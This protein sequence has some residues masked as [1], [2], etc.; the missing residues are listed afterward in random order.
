MPKATSPPLIWWLQSKLISDWKS[1]IA[2]NRAVAQDMKAIYE[3]WTIRKTDDKL[4]NSGRRWSIFG[5]PV[6]REILDTV[7]YRAEPKASSQSK[8]NKYDDSEWKK[9][10]N[11]RVVSLHAAVRG[12]ILS[13]LKDC[14][15]FTSNSRF[16][17]ERVL[18]DIQPCPSRLP[19][20][21][22]SWLSR[23]EG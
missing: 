8:L 19:S 5:V 15:H 16:V 13:L 7:Q 3:I 2:N 18:V 17:R 4:F 22:A 1:D 23:W 10:L 20:P 14:E 6:I 12:E 9:A 21:K 11:E